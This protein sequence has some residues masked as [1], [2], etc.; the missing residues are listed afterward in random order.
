MIRRRYAA[1]PSLNGDRS[2]A[3]ITIIDGRAPVTF[4]IT[5]FCIV[6]IEPVRR[7][8]LQFSGYEGKRTTDCEREMNWRPYIHAQ[9]NVPSITW[10]MDI[11]LLSCDAANRRTF[12]RPEV[13]GTFDSPYSFGA[14]QDVD[15]AIGLRVSCGDNER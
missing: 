1:L 10:P 13:T 3:T 8:Y 5:R 9:Q 6:P 14:G 15:W 12:W 4:H 7:L 11:F 2:R